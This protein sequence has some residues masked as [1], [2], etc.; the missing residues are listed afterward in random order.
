MKR[1]LLLNEDYNEQLFLD[2]FLKKMGFDTLHV[3]NDISIPEIVLTF[4]PDAVLVTGEGTRIRGIRVAEK[5]RKRGSTA[6]IIFL[7]PLN[8]IKDEKLMEIYKGQIVVETPVNPRSLI[9]VLCRALKMDLENMLEKFERL[10]IAKSY[11]MGQKEDGQIVL[12]QR[13]SEISKPVVSM[14]SERYE[15]ILAV[16]PDYEDKGF[17]KDVVNAVTTEIRKF[18]KDNPDLQKLDEARQAFVVKLYQKK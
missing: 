11:S 18:E 13:P 8:K 4:K 15:K 16:T 1:I 3:R 10:S 14:R 7:F 12:N 9:P 17:S 6:K 2:T 5:L